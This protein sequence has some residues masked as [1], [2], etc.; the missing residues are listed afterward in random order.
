MESDRDLIAREIEAGLRETD[1]L[2]IGTYLGVSL[3]EIG[4]LGAKAWLRQRAVTYDALGEVL[5]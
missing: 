3:R 4:W 1:K 5:R 2:P